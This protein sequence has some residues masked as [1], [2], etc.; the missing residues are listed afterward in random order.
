[1]FEKRMPASHA[2]SIKDNIMIKNDVQRIPERIQF[3]AWHMV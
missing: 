1:M 3:Y 2:D